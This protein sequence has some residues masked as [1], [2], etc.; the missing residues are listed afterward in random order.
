MNRLPS[1]ILGLP[2]SEAIPRIAI[3]QEQLQPLQALVR[4]LTTLPC[5]QRASD[6]RRPQRSILID[7]RLLDEASRRAQ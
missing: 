1:L 4:L 7:D 5:E 2:S 3:C 6:P